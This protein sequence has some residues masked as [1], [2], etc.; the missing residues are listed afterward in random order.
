MKNFWVI[1]TVILGSIIFMGLLGIFQ[2][3][4]DYTCPEIDTDVEQTGYYL[5]WWIVVTCVCLRLWF[6]RPVRYSWIII[7]RK[8]KKD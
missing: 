7:L 4:I 3:F 1:I 8:F 6:I 5:F 2:L